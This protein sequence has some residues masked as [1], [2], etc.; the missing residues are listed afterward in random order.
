MGPRYLEAIQPSRPTVGKGVTCN[1]Y[2][3][4]IRPLFPR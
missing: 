3:R 4:P 2:E 1:L